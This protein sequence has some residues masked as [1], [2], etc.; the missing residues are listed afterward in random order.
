M[1]VEYFEFLLL[2]FCSS[3]GWGQCLNNKPR[4]SQQF[5]DI[6]PG[7]IFDLDEQCRLAMGAHSRFCFLGDEPP[8][9]KQKASDVKSCIIDFF[10]LQDI[11]KK[12]MCTKMHGKHSMCLPS[13]AGQPVDGTIC[14]PNKVKIYFEKK[15]KKK[16]I[17]SSGVSMVDVLQ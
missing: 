1:F 5:D 16:K 10:F 2:F 11:C 9:V 6:L 3:Q 15:T 4:T 8:M 14:G 13:M 17:C 12:M 7:I